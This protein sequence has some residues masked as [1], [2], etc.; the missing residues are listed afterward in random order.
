MKRKFLFSLPLIL[1]LVIVGVASLKLW[2]E[3]RVF[4]NISFVY[5]IFQYS[6]SY[7]DEDATFSFILIESN[8]RIASHEDHNVI[9]SLISKNNEE[10]LVENYSIDTI[11]ESTFFSPYSI[12]RIDGSLEFDG[13][14]PS[15][16]QFNEIS[17]GNERYEI[18]TLTLERIPALKEVEIGIGAT[19][20]LTRINYLE[21]LVINDET[22]DLEITGVIFYL[23]NEEINLL[24]APVLLKSGEVFDERFDM[25]MFSN[26]NFSIVPR[27]DMRKSG[28]SISMRVPNTIEF[29]DD[30]A[31]ED[32]I[33]LIQGGN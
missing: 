14:S 6:A 12:F 13:N 20:F 24:D 25:S 27:I 32:I 23:D 19:M 3:N 4:D 8:G 29:V 16:F 9:F 31:K 30:L 22:Q 5:Q 7:T 11:K 10:F 21:L 2:N 18:G 33:T 28:E 1:A 26:I 17:I 15:L